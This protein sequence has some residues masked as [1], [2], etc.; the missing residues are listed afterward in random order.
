MLSPP[1]VASSSDCRLFTRKWNQKGFQTRFKGVAAF[2]AHQNMKRITL[3][4]LCL[5]AV[6]LS[7]FAQDQSS[8]AADNSARNERDRSGETKTS[9]DQSNTKGDTQITA[10]I[11]RAVMKDD[12]LSMT[13]KNVKIIAEN[14]VVT[15]RGPVKSEAEKTKIADLA[16]SAAGQMKIENQLE[17]KNSD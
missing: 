6:A 8:P 11:R 4:I 2:A 1:T 10:S 13:A 17:V 14:G 9:F 16:K 12:S 5:S 7:A 15:L 3:S